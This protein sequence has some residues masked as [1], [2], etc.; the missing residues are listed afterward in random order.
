N[1]S[2]KVGVCARWT[3]GGTPASPTQ[4]GYCVY[5]RSDGVGTPPTTGK[6][7]FSKKISTSLLTNGVSTGATPTTNVPVFVAGTWYKVSLT[8]KGTGPVTL[9]A[10]INDGPTIGPAVENTSFFTTGGPAIAVRS[11]KASFDDLTI[12]PA[13]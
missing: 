4:T 9:T 7:Q 12:A 5:L 11:M 8:V 2:N 10:T 1:D 13:Q 6:L 3:E